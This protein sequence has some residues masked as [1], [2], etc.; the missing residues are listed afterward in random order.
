MTISYRSVIFGLLGIVL[1]IAVVFYFI[2]PDSPPARYMADM[3]DKVINRLDSTGRGK[4][5]TAGAQQAHFTAVEGTVKVKKASSNVWINAEYNI[6]LER[7]DVVQTSSEGLAKLVFTD[8]TNYTVKQDSLIVIEEN[9]TNDAQ[10]TNVSVQVTTGTVDLATSTYTQGSKS[11]VIVAGASASL[12]PESSAM[13]RNDPHADQHEILVKKGSGEVT[14]GGEKVVLANYEKVT[15]K[16]EAQQMAKTKEIG[17]PT[18]IQPSNMAPVFASGGQ[19]NFSWTPIPASHGY[20]LRV[21]KNPYFSSTVYDKVMLGTDAKVTG[22]TDGNYYWIVTTVD[23]NGKQSVESERSQFTLLQKA[24]DNT[25]LA[26]DLSPFIQH[27]HVIEVKGRTEPGARVMVNGQQVPMVGGD[28]SF[29]FFTSP[30]PNGAHMITITAQN[31]KGG[32]RTEQKRVVI[33]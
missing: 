7:G 30:L 26:L 16:A 9:S 8:G 13:V 28:G 18:L 5:V 23:I 10:Q 22:L 19:V 31:S 2:F 11:Q 24:P 17:P 3:G 6:P 12:A 4:T 1:L 14:R 15:F 27:G 21:S 29:Q 25:A 33:E 20:R 32:V